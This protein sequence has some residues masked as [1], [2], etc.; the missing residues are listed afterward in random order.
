MKVNV[1]VSFLYCLPPLAVAWLIINFGVNVPFWDEWGYVD[2]FDKIYQNNYHIFDFFQQHNEHRIVV[3]R[4]ITIVIA[5]FTDWNIKLLMFIS[6][7]ISCISFFL[8]KHIFDRANTNSSRKH[9]LTIS[10]TNILG[11]LIIF[12]FN[13]YENWLW[14]FQLAWFLVNLFVI[15][16]IAVFGFPIK[17]YQKYI[18]SAVCCL[19]ASFSSGQG[20]VSWLAVAPLVYFEEN[21][22]LKKRVTKTLIWL[23][24]FT[25]TLLIYFIL[26]GY[27]KPSY[28]PK[29]A[30]SPFQIIH[31]IFRMY[32]KS[33]NP[34]LGKFGTDFVG[35]CILCT[36]LLF[37]YYLWHNR[38]S[39]LFSKILPWICLGWYSLL[40]S[41][42]TAISRSGFG[43]EQAEASRYT[44]I[45]LLLPLSLIYISASLLISG[46]I[47][48]YYNYLV[49]GMLFVF[50]VSSNIQQIPTG[51]SLMYQKKS[52]EL[53]IELIEFLKP[54]VNTSDHQFNCLNYM[55]PDTKFLTESIYKLNTLG[56]RKIQLKDEVKFIDIHNYQ[57]GHIDKP[58][59]KE[60]VVAK[61]SSEI[62]LNGWAIMPNRRE[63][64]PAVF[65]SKGEEKEFFA[66][67]S[68]GGFRPDVAD[69]LKSQ[70][71]KFFGW[72][73]KIKLTDFSAGNHQIK[74]WVYNRDSKQF[75]SLRGK[76]NLQLEE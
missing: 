44:T 4:I 12:S 5:F 39:I 60:I 67:V 17:T 64:A 34:D 22:S 65:F 68:T 9:I 76:I 36:F 48:K 58:S 41:V 21:N 16:A 35:F 56:F 70:R 73:A 62:E 28:H 75:I 10:F 24:L 47:D 52:G 43:I 38:N 32:G 61:V 27:R 55:Y 26:L 14:G 69:A 51:V 7:I 30:S 25:V 57:V 18:C 46:K 3:P 54:S 20:L 6:L 31:Y 19:L 66:A 59:P 40:F 49:S 29:L 37:N 23:V 11:S 50:L 74:A 8:I 72:N 45:S 71:L 15:L 1:F 63:S 33:L 13:Q 2:L 42:M 53:C